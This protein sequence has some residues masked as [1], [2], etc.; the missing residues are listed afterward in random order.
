MFVKLRKWYRI[1]N[2]FMHILH[3]GIYVV[4]NVRP[5]YTQK[6]PNFLVQK[7]KKKAPKSEDFEAFWW[8]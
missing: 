7:V 3:C 4:K 5:E 6:N 2:Y 1:S 8:R